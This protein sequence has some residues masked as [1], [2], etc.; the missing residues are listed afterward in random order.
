MTRSR[1]FRELLIDVAR[2]LR[3]LSL[4]WHKQNRAFILD[5]FFTGTVGHHLNFNLG[6]K[7][8]LADRGWSVT[9]LANRYASR[10]AIK[11]SGAHRLLTS[12]GYITFQPFADALFRRNADFYRSLRLLNLTAFGPENLVI[13]HTITLF[14]L[15]ALARWY[16]ELPAETRPRLIVYLQFPPSYQ[17]QDSASEVAFAYRLGSQIAQTLAAFERVTLCTSSPAIGAFFETKDSS[18]IQVPLPM[19]WPAVPSTRPNDGRLVFGFVGSAREDKGL[20]LLPDAIASILESCSDIDFVIQSSLSTPDPHWERLSQ[21]GPRV[22][23]SN[24]ADLARD[25]YYAVFADLDCLLLPYDPGKYTEMTSMIGIEAIGMGKGLITTRGTWLQDVADAFDAPNVAMG[26]YS[27]AALAEAIRT[28]A[29]R[30]AAM[31]DKTARTQERIRH[32]YT[33]EGFLDAVNVGFAPTA[34]PSAQDDPRR[35]A[36]RGV[37]SIAHEP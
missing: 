28:Y 9:I 26:E 33:V 16:G 37:A 11:G 31:T 13:V 32:I 7:K 17:V 6:L 30:R 1:Y 35:V 3:H 29:G 34:T 21:L 22:R 4:A 15:Q 8:V 5:P 20:P 10:A 14:E 18:P 25:D 27:S 12:P 24:K 36:H 2:S 19:S 23:V